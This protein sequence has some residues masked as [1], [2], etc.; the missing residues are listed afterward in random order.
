MQPKPTHE[1]WYAETV[2][3]QISVVTHTHYMHKQKAQLLCNHSC[4]PAHTHQGIYDAW[5]V[6]IPNK[7]AQITCD[8]IVMTVVDTSILHTVTRR[9]PLLSKPDCY[10]IQ[11]LR[12]ELRAICIPILCKHLLSLVFCLCGLGFVNQ[13]NQLGETY[14]S[15][16]FL[17]SQKSLKLLVLLESPDFSLSPH[18]KKE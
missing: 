5:G 10:Q 6:P 14:F 12:L 2:Y 18:I 16:L 13:M 8:F 3:V 1:K 15:G 9:V 11:S 4:R 7:P 17:L